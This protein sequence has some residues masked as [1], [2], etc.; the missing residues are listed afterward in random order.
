MTEDIALQ[1][2]DKFFELMRLYEYADERSILK[3]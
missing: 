1:F 2:K 3:C